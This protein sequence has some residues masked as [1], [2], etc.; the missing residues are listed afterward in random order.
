M[1]RVSGDLAV[2]DTHHILGAA[3][4]ASLALGRE[5]PDAA[6]AGA[7]AVEEALVENQVVALATADDIDLETLDH[8]TAAL[9]KHPP[10]FDGLAEK[11][12]QIQRR[13]LIRVPGDIHTGTTGDAEGQ[14]Q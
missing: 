5:G 1:Q 14:R 6:L 12:L 7:V 11:L 8:L 4:P 2:G 9:L 3:A 13:L 10:G